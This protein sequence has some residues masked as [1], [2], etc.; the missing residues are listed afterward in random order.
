[1]LYPL[2]YLRN[3]DKIPMYCLI[4]INIVLSR[5]PAKLKT[6]LDQARATECYLNKIS[7]LLLT[8]VQSRTSN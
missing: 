5:C 1:M 6:C 7:Y 2:K 4:P 8:E 3:D